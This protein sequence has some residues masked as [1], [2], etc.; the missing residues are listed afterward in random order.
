MVFRF[1]TL[2][3]PIINL[4]YIKR[5]SD[6]GES[7]TGLWLKVKKKELKDKLGENEN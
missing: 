6:N 1:H 3:V 4:Y 5:N 2:I 7:L